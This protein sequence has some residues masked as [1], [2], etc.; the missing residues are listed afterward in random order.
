MDQPGTGSTERTGRLTGVVVIAT[1]GVLWLAGTLWASYAAI[2]AADGADLV[3]VQASVA[4]PRVLSA[5]V[6]AGA[7]LALV[8]VALL[9]RARPGTADRW[10]ARLGTAA[11]TGLLVGMV[12]A[13]LVVLAYDGSSTIRG[14]AAPVVAA[15]LLGGA[16]AAVRPGTVVAAGLS[17]TVAA[18]V[19]SLLHGAWEG[20]LRQLVSSGQTPQA[21]ATATSRVFYLAAVVAGLA[22]GI[23]AFVHLRRRRSG[24]GWPGYLLAG[25]L[26]GLLGVVTELVTRVGG[27]RL[28]T[29]AGALSAND[30][31]V[32]DYLAAARLNNALVVLF[33]GG[34]AAMVAF[35]RTLRPADAE[36]DRDD[37][38]AGRVERAPT[39]E[40]SATADADDQD[41][42]DRE[43]AF[44][45]PH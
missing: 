43:A 8:A 28:Y 15:G 37:E 7:V 18:T 34:L 26:A 45:P 10:P 21:L 11:G 5:T 3:V 42:A 41:A 27:A 25:A 40:T 16:V 39:T 44:T 36:P 30:R 31:T 24:P 13:L 38:G 4:L 23:T 19:V 22:A 17:G 32:Q 6:F 29:L 9:T 33:V 1:I 2:S 20:E 14:L 35:G 12:T